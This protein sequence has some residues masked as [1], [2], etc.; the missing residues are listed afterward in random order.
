MR[1]CWRP[2]VH[3]PGRV[4]RCLTPC[5]YM[6]CEIS[7][8]LTRDLPPRQR[9]ILRRRGVRRA[10]GC[11]A[12]ELVDS[13][14]RDLN[15]AMKNTPYEFYADHIANGAMVFGAFRKDW[16]SFDFA[17][18]RVR[19]GRA[20]G[21]SSKDRRPSDRQ[22]GAACRGAGQSPA[23]TTGLKAGCS[24]SPARSLGFIRS[25]WISR[26]W[27]SSKASGRCRR[28]LWGETSTNVILGASRSDAS[29]R[30]AKDRGSRPSFETPRCRAAP[31]DERPE[32]R[33]RAA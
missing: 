13:R 26:W 27:E 22:P 15:A 3:E 7:F 29:R 18:T 20:A 16:Q 30:I 21:P 25:S 12:F 2:R 33:K 5:Q 4:P 11:A 28:R 32:Q 6:E 23:Q 31:Q 19:C 1:R 17:K 14:F 9:G 10:G 24:S 8:R